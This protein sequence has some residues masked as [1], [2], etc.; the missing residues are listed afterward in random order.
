[1]VESIKVLVND[2]QIEVTPHKDEDF[3]ITGHNGDQVVVDNIG[4]TLQYAE[5]KKI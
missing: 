4:N 3:D 1:M 2:V 5:T